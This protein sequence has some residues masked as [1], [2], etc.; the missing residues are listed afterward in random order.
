MKHF[1][2]QT[3]KQQ[4]LN[5]DDTK[6]MLMSVPVQALIVSMEM[7]LNVLRSRGVEVRDFDNKSRKIEQIRMIGNKAY[8]L[9]AEITTKE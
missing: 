2:K 6:Q 9:A 3:E 5:I 8:F 1:K 4:S 7:Q